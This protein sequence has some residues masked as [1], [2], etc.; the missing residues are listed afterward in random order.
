MCVCVCV[1]V[2]V[3]VCVCARRVC[4]YACTCVSQPK[5]HTPLEIEQEPA[6]G[7]VKVGVVTMLLHVL[8][9]LTV[10][11]LPCEDK[12]IKVREKK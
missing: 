8:V 4:V 3:C 2:C 7:E 5:I 6:V 11:C 12:K 10:Y 9:Q 1:F